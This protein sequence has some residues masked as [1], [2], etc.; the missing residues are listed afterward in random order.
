MQVQRRDSS[1]NKLKK[2]HHWERK[3]PSDAAILK[4]YFAEAEEGFK[5][6]PIVAELSNDDILDLI[7]EWADE[8]MLT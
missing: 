3:Y 8:Q 1:K 2:D 6:D 4:L 5:L 7:D